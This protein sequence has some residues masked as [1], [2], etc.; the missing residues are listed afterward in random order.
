MVVD[1]WNSSCAR[2]VYK[3]Y[4]GEETT[5]GVWDSCVLRLKGFEE[6]KLEDPIMY[7]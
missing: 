6:A 7:K 4:N 5:C 3:I 1:S 2:K